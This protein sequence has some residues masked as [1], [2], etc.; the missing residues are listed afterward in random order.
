M[1]ITAYNSHGSQSE[2]AAYLSSDQSETSATSPHPTL[3]QPSTVIGNS[4][5]RPDCLLSHLNCQFLS[6]QWQWR[7]W[8]W[9]LDWCGITC[10]CSVPCQLS[11]IR[12]LWSAG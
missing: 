12:W 6:G 8:W 7:W 9:W 4:L 1:S 10:T 3:S 11:A 5:W 2:L